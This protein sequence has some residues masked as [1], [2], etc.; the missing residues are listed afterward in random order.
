MAGGEEKTDPI[1][2]YAEPAAELDEPEPKVIQLH[3]D[4]MLPREPASYRM[5]EPELVGPEAV[6]AQAVEEAVMLEVLD[7]AGP[8]RREAADGSCGRLG[9]DALRRK[10]G[11]SRDRV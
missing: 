6:V 5:E 9:H 3:P 11:R 8:N 1:A 2:I 4:H 7:A 10:G